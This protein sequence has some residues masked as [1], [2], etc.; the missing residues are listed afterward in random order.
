[1]L[2]PE[3]LHRGAD[4][5]LGLAFAFHYLKLTPVASHMCHLRVICTRWRSDNSNKPLNK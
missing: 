3:A 2:V 1:M 4:G 5:F